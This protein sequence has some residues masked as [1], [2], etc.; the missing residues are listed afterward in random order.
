MGHCNTVQLA[1]PSPQEQAAKLEQLVRSAFA[2]S[3]EKA[4]ASVNVTVQAGLNLMGSRNVVTFGSSSPAKE[5]AKVS[6]L[7]EVKTSVKG[8]V[9]G[10][11]RKRRAESEPV[12]VRRVGGKKVKV[13]GL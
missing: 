1:T 11:G 3:T 7:G 5:T 13:E 6:A 12:D 8:D 10:A 4:H 9:K 2:S